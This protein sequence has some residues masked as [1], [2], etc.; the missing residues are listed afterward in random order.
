MCSSF[1]K[2]WVPKSVSGVVPGVG[3]HYAQKQ[4]ALS[5]GVSTLVARELAIFKTQGTIQMA[6]THRKRCSMSLV[7]RETQIT[8]TVRYHLPPVTMA[9]HSEIYKGQM[10]ARVWRKGS[11]PTLWWECQVM[12]PLWKTLWRFL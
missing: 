7:L 12:Q 2:P 9:T 8:T 10:L 3:T 6:H 1:Y 5:S 11:P 4:E